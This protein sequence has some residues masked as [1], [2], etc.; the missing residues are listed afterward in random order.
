MVKQP[1]WAAA[2]SSSG[3]VPTPFS[4]RVL[5]EYCVC[6]ST[7]LSVEMEPLPDFRSPDQ[8]AEPLRCMRDLLFEVTRNLSIDSIRARFEWIHQILVNSLPLMKDEKYRKADASE[9]RG[10][11]PAE[12]FAEVG[13][14]KDGEDG[15]GDDFLDGLELGGVEFIGTDAIRRH[16]KTVFEESNAPTSENNFPE[17]FAAVFQVAVPGEGH[18]NVGNCE[19]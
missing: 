8:T 5:N 7:P 14:R 13:N 6:L 17:R 15:E 18:E 1:A 19:K 11:I 12:F 3:L 4:K 16:L 9:A 2:R 10:V